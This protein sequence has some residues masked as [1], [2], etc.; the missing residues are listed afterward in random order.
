MSIEFR[1]VYILIINHNIYDYSKEF[2]EHY[3][4]FRLAAYFA[5]W[6]RRLS[7]HRLLQGT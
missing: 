4:S 1:N 2:I 5:A 7:A 3:C 6:A